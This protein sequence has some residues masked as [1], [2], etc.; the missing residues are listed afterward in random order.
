MNLSLP[1]IKTAINPSPHKISLP[2]NNLP[3]KELITKKKRPHMKPLR[4]I[5]SRIRM[6]CSL[7]SDW[8][9]QVHD[10]PLD[11]Y[12]ASWSSCCTNERWYCRPVLKFHGSCWDSKR[13]ENR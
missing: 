12:T 5:F 3:S 11:F 1:V 6:S 7:Y 13:F 4:R 10:H 2:K 8:F 9:L